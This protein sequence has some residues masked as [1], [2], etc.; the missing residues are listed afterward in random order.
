MITHRP[1][2]NVANV[3]SF[4]EGYPLKE[5]SEVA[6]DAGGTKYDLFTRDDS[7]WARTSDIDKA[8]VTTFAKARD[9]TVKGTPA[10]GPPTVDTYSLKGFAKALDL[11][12][13]ACGVK[14]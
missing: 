11:I 7:A 6:L 9:V 14:R 3:V 10:H 12:D 8:I 13:K 1:E 4:A 2:E 5:G